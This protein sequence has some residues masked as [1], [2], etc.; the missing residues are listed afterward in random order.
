M[1]W[2]DVF[3]AVI[4]V[5]DAVVSTA[6]VWVPVLVAGAALAVGVRLTPRGRHRR[7]RR[8]DVS[9]HNSDTPPDISA[10]VSS[11]RPDL[12]GH[13]PDMPAVACPDM[14]GR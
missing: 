7:T 1:T 13:R 12:R 6:D 9:G 2:F 4:A 10:R 14:S 11:L 8:P 5:G 3:V